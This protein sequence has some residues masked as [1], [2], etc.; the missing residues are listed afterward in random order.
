MPP[1]T[2]LAEK[3]GVTAQ[4]I[5]S[6]AS[7]KKLDFARKWIEEGKIKAQISKTMKLEEAG[8]AQDLIT[9]GGVNGKIVLEIN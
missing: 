4:F 9:S 6:T 2:E 7:A 1:P 8:A 3:Y 5:N